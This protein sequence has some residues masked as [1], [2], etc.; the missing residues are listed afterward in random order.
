MLLHP[1]MWR[2]SCKGVMWLKF[3]TWDGCRVFLRRAS[4]WFTTCRWNL[5]TQEALVAMHFRRAVNCFS[6]RLPLNSNMGA[7]GWAKRGLAA[8]A[9]FCALAQAG[10]KQRSSWLAEVRGTQQA[11]KGSNVSYSITSPQPAFF[12]R[13]CK[14]LHFFLG[15]WTGYRNMPGAN[16][17]SL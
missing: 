6:L 13:C 11:A 12:Q 8:V 17:A 14:Y 2:S 7:W 1:C 10:Y 9:L 4:M 5:W 3:G 15:G 16:T